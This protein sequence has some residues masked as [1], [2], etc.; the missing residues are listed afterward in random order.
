MMTATVTAR[1]WARDDEVYLP[2]DARLKE[3]TLS[4]RKDK[5][6]QIIQMKGGPTGHESFKVS[7]R[8]VKGMSTYGWLACF[9]GGSY[10]RCDVTS[11]EMAR[12]FGE[13]GIA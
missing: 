1:F 12:A 9:G 4:L 3:V 2:N 10:E 5:D 7:E 13:L 6:Q 11:G 8:A